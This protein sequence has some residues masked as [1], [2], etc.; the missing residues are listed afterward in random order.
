M[1]NLPIQQ[2]I[3]RKIIIVKEG[4]AIQRKRDEKNKLLISQKKNITVLPV[5]AHP[6][7]ARKG[8]RMMTT[9]KENF[10][11]SKPQPMKDKSIPGRRLKNG[12]W[13]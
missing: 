10:E 3:P 8:R 5:M 6:L 1:D 7:L 13:V 11:T 12:S 9:F 4:S 2:T